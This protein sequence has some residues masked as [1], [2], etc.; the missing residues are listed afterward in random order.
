MADGEGRLPAAAVRGGHGHAYWMRPRWIG[1]VHGR[2]AS[3]P[4]NPVRRL[5]GAERCGAGDHR[6][7]AVQR[8]GESMRIAVFPTVRS[9]RGLAYIRA[10][11][12]ALPANCPMPSG[13]TADQTSIHPVEGCDD[14]LRPGVGDV[15][16]KA[17]A[18]RR[19]SNLGLYESIR[20]PT[21]VLRGRSRTCW[22]GR[23]PRAALTSGVEGSPC[24]ECRT[25]GMH[26]P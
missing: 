5:A 24:G 21:L 1:H 17:P 19:G 6:A 18:D 11:G 3:M 13:G 10:V 25:S 14:T 8:I 22:P 15:F 4:G 9:C 7:E 20:C 2:L 12:G 16:R 26:R 23:R